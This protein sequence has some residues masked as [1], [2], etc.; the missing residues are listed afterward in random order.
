VTCVLHVT[1]FFIPLS[2]EEH[3]KRKED[4]GSVSE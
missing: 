2:Y 3:S 4:C 1:A